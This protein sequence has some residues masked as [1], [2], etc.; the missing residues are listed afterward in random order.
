MVL[1]LR[2]EVG[3]CNLPEWPDWI[4]GELKGCSSSLVPE[5]VWPLSKRGSILQ[6][7]ME[8]K[9]YIQLETAGPVGGV[10]G[11]RMAYRKP[12]LPGTMV[13]LVSLEICIAHFSKETSL[14]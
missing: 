3:N 4:E 2:L 14:S 11:S 10:T 9:V 13:V 12:L 6:V 7:A 5:P 1:Q 8:L